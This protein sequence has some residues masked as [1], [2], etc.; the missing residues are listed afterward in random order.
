MSRLFASMLFVAFIH[1][2]VPAFASS[3]APFDP[4][5]HK[6]Q[7]GR[8][9]EVMVL[10]T[11]HLSQL[12]KLFDPAHLSAL[13]ARL[14]EWK[15]QAIA[16]EALSG[17]QCAYLRSYPQRYA[18]TIKLYCWNPAAAQAA[19]GLDVVAATV[20]A[21]RLLAA[22]PAAP[23]AAQRR[24]LASL[25]LAG[26]ERASALVQWLRLPAGERRAGDGLDE[27]L[28]GMLNT[29]LQRRGEDYLIAAVVAAKS[30][31]EQVHAMDDHTADAPGE[32]EL[33]EK[34]Y[35]EALMMAWDNPVAAQRKRISDELGAALTTP[36]AVLEMYRAHNAPAMAEMAFRGDFGAALAEPSPQHFGRK[37]VAYWETRNL[38]MA[39]NIRELMMARPGRRV[40][41]VVGA[42]HKAYL[43]AYLQQMHDVR[44]V[45]TDDILR[46]GD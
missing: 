14:L 34:A 19:T 36:A 6:L 22:W 26:G 13:N 16:I 44:I 1:A 43:E 20:Q 17:L 18:E 31:H 24:K 40:L 11:P 9:N 23:S 35:G 7:A 38:R 32:D 15:P 21:Q 2:G 5:A 37:Y 10:G 42:S 27:N 12:P 39:S 28:A 45:G 29:L 41:V 46:Q 4:A 3:A 8:I 25:F 30:G 33:A